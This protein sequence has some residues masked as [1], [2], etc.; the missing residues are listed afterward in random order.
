MVAFL[1]SIRTCA[2]MGMPSSGVPGTGSCV[3]WVVA[4]P[5]GSFLMAETMSFSL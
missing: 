5:V 3:L 1:L 2:V 4:W